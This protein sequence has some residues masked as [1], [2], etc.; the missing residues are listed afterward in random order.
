MQ[1]LVTG[2]SNFKSIRESNSLY[3]DK[4]EF[5][6]KIASSEEKFFLLNCPRRFGKSL[7]VNT[8][9]SFYQAEK[10]L[11]VGLKIYNQDW[12]WEEYPVIHLDYCTVIAESTESLD[13]SLGYALESAAGEYDKPVFASLIDPY[14]YQLDFE[15][16]ERFKKELKS[17]YQ[18]LEEL[19]DYLEKVYLTGIIKF[20]SSSIFPDSINLVELEQEPEFAELPGFTA[21]EVEDY[22][23]PYF[24]KLAVRNDLSITEAK[25]SFQDHYLGYRFTEKEIQVYNPFA[26]ARVLDHGAFDNHWFNS[27]SPGLLFSFIERENFKITDFEN[28]IVEKSKLNPANIRELTLIPLSYQTGYLTIAEFVDNDLVKL[29]F[30]NYEV[31][32]YFSLNLLDF[33]AED[34]INR[35]DVYYLRDSLVKNDEQQFRKYLNS[36][37][38]DLKKV[39]INQSES[40]KEFYQQLFYLIGK[41]LSNL[42]LKITSEILKTEDTV[43][44][45]IETENKQFMLSFNYGANPEIINQ[46]QEKYEVE[47]DC[48]Y[49]SVSFDP[50][51]REIAELEIRS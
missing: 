46:L 44:L 24:P 1:N 13:K 41:S 34:K 7:F 29:D 2:R 50:E 49:I 18:N 27:G 15:K 51:K 36:I 21:E 23:T 35:V 22:F 47:K 11:F 20:G 8:L 10:E 45:K 28:L 25:K 16:Y 19:A 17:F 14:S 3:I 12:Q 6:Y 31:E 33:L 30:P 48:T 39:E 5:V 26:A 9:K 43:E 42:Y 40:V 32:S 4:T 37:I 38:D